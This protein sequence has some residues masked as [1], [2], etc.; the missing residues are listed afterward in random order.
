MSKITVI[1]NGYKRTHTIEEQYQAIKNQTIKDIDL[2]YWV[3]LTKDSLSIPQTIIDSC[4][5]IISNTNFGTWGRF[6]MA[7]NARTEFVC[8]IDDDTIP[9]SKWLENCLK[10]FE[11]HQG[12]LTTRGIIANIEHEKKYPLPE[13]YTAHGW[14]QPNEEVLRVDMGCQSWFFPKEMLRG[15]W[16]DMPKDMPMNY[17]EDTHLSYVAQKY[18]NMNTYV[19]PHPAN[20]L[21]LWGSNPETAMKYGT[22]SAAISWSA[23]AN[24]GMNQYWNFVRDNGYKLIAEDNNEV[25]NTTA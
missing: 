9:G 23:E 14:C 2:F 25:H 8:V 17:G 18:F 6:A 10:T 1:L 19:P 20:D 21:E 7:L 13:S 16:L 5:S 3:N 4:S 11:T 24:S 12:V 22:D 15:F